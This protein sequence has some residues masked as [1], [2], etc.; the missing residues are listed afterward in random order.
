M[1]KY[2]LSKVLKKSQLPSVVDSK[3][4]NSSKVEAG[5]SVSCSTMGRNSFCGYDCDIFH[6]DIG[7][8]TSIASGVILG[9]ARHPIEWL[10]MSP[11]FYKGRDSI[12]T[13]F[14]EFELPPP[15]RVTIGN[16]VWI[17]RNAIVLPGVS[18][19]DG[20]VV[21]AGAVVTKDVPP[22]AVVAGNPARVIK[23]RFDEFLIAELMDIKWW[24]MEDYEI[25]KYAELCKSPSVFIE[26]IKKNFKH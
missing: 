21:G 13:K 19:C 15:K 5:S 25:E 23:Y 17:G 8:F 2:I 1:L 6:T 24:E 20:A 26:R 3:I 4:H 22:Y 10:G 14:V 11:V 9:G 18:V 12:K 7:S 16:D